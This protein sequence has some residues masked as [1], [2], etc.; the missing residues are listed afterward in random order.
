MALNTT[1]PMSLCHQWFEEA[2][3][4]HESELWQTH[5]AS[6]WD[7]NNEHGAILD[8]KF[9]KF[10]GFDLLPLPTDSSPC[11]R[12]LS[13]V[14]GCFLLQCALGAGFPSKVVRY[15]ELYF[16]LLALFHQAVSHVC[17]LEFNAHLIDGNSLMALHHLTLLIRQKN[18]VQLQSKEHHLYSRYGQQQVV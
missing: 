6:V 4:R 1:I 14:I 11:N 17:T 18:P 16:W 2:T 5:K 7:C 13:S 8:K 15:T 3:Q 9:P 12:I 10:R